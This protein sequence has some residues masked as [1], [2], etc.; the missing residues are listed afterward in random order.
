VPGT[1]TKELSSKYCY[2]VETV[3]DGR[4]VHLMRPAWKNKGFDFMIHVS[5]T[6]FHPGGRA[7]MPS[8]TDIVNDLRAKRREDRRKFLRVKDI[9]DRLYACSA[10]SDEELR[11]LNFRTGH[12][13]EVVAKAAKWLF[14]EQDLTYWNFSGRGML[15][16]AIT[17][18]R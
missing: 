6:V 9:I 14:I 10:V 7:T 17:S 1:G 5:G 4:I 16:G 3:A 11:V 18:A 2:E 13:F 8:Q 12:T 15:Y